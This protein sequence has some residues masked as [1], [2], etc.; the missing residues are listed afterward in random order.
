MTD[1]DEMSDIRKDLE[2][3]A[4]L[5]EEKAAKEETE[6]SSDTTA[7]NREENDDAVVDEYL[8]A[9]KSYKKELA[10]TFKNL[11]LEWRRYLHAREQEI[12]KGFSDL[13]NRAGSYKWLDD[14]Y[15]S[16]L[17]ELQKYGVKS[18]D[19]WIN[20]MVKIDTLLSQN[21]AGAIK[22]LADSYGVNI[23]PALSTAASRMPQQTLTDILAGQVVAKKV[24]AF[25]N[26][27]DEQGNKKHPFYGE[28]VR[29]MF[30]L[31][32]KGVV[33]DL[34]EAYEAAVWFNSSTRN[35][36]LAQKSQEAL[37]L[38][39]KNAQ[40]SKEAAFSLKGKAAPSAKDLTLREEL[41]MR[42]AALAGDDD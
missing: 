7:D 24:E 29:D 20:N 18:S 26:E 3:F 32:H 33:K 15:S 14:I 9:P 28:V 6:A 36:L 38:K 16:R 31:L 41:E 39:S 19:D 5:A 42:F 17:G 37:E 8:T 30:D 21:P 25:V 1:T 23:E 11:P 2:H 10:D 27:I 4:Q 34:D 12:D 13:H 22:M 35:K 40:K